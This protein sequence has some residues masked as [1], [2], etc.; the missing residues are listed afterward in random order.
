V[1]ICLAGAGAIGGLLGA[2]FAL[3]GHDVTFL[4]RGALD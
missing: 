3:A 2:K 1:K 4:A